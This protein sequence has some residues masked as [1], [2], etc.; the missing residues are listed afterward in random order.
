M[1]HQA[2][3]IQGEGY[4]T[5]LELALNEGRPWPHLHVPERHRSETPRKPRF[6]WPRRW[7]KGQAEG[8]LA[9]Q[10][11]ELAPSSQEL[12]SR[13]SFIKWDMDLVP[14]LA[15]PGWG[16]CERVLVPSVQEAQS[17]RTSGKW[18]RQ[19]ADRESGKVLQLKLLRGGT[20][21]VRALRGRLVM[22]RCP[23]SEMWDTSGRPWSKPRDSA[24]K[25]KIT[26]QFT[27]ALGFYTIEEKWLNKLQ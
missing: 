13:H 5:L 21:G 16:T 1:W 22:L 14:W 2:G 10:P 24:K 23:T 17:W 7:K 9:A 20:S 3:T 8:L 25:S 26:F 18:D 11:R 6:Q 15:H 4:Q 27:Y 19:L 12:S